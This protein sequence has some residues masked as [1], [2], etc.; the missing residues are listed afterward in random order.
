VFTFRADAKVAAMLERAEEAGI[1]KTF[2]INNSLRESLPKTLGKMNLLNG[3][4]QPKV[5]KK[6][7]GTR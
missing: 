7:G 3:D 5:A 6:K 4:S 2:L 1:E